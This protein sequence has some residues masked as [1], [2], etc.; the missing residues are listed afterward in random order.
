M[1]W[2]SDQLERKKKEIAEEFG[3]VPNTLSTILKDIDKYWEAFYGGQVSISKKMQQATTV[4]DIDDAFLR[5]FSN[6]RRRGRVKEGASK[7]SELFQATEQ[8]TNCY[9]LQI[10][11]LVFLVL[12]YYTQ[13]QSA[14]TIINI[15]TYTLH[16]L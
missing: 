12:C 4:E 3:I 9:D 1:L 5:W 7:H 10:C 11:V 15:Y 8:F 6:S 16:V 13:L 14:C 2:R